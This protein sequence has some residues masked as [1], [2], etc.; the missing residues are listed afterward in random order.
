MKQKE[1]CINTRDR[2]GSAPLAVWGERSASNPC[3]PGSRFRGVRACSTDNSVRA[4]MYA[5]YAAPH[6]RR[7]P[8]DDAENLPEPFPGLL[9]LSGGEVYHPKLTAQV[10]KRKS[11]VHCVIY[12]KVNLL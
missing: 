11:K 3:S 12:V 7:Q 10:G 9:V 1:Q 8:L 6:L 2:D 5:N 4:Y